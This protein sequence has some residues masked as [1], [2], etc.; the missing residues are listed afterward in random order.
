MARQLAL[1]EAQSDDQWRLD[2]TTRE[3]GRKGV[4]NARRILQE[5]TAAA[6]DRTAA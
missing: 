4:A 2:D 3:V 6:V 1:L 5:A